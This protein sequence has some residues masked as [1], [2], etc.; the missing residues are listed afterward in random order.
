MEKLTNNSPNH[1][2]NGWIQTLRAFA[3]VYV[4]LFHCIPFWQLLENETLSQVLIFLS[5]H[6][7]VGVDIFFVISGYVIGISIK[8]KK[9]DFREGGRFI[10]KRLTR[11]YS[12]YWPIFFLTIL[13]SYW[14]IRPVENLKDKLFDSFFL[15]SKQPDKNI[16]EVAWSLSYELNFYFFIFLTVFLVRKISLKKMIIITV[17][18]IMAYNLYWYVFYKNIIW[19]G[20][21]PLRYE[22]SGLTIEFL[23][24]LYLSTIPKTTLQNKELI[25]LFSFIAVLSFIAGTHD[26]FF[27]NYEL[28][29][30]ATFGVF[31]CAIVAIAIILEESRFPSSQKINFIGDSSYSLYLI[32]PLLLALIG[33]FLGGRQSLLNSLIILF[34]PFI[35]ILVASLWFTCLEKPMYKKIIAKLN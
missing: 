16:L 31:A 8:N 5:R 24:G 19:G 4:M 17:V 6:G 9:K 10:L 3:A 35:C 33:N 1:H 13:F 22:M 30:T 23:M 12:G 2:K 32:H 15:L 26:M 7:Y 21:W 18:V 14:Q 20:V 27:A 25:T 11:I 29:R 28:L 34:V